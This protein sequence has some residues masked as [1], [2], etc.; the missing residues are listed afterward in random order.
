MMT[1]AEEMKSRIGELI[2]CSMAASATMRY[3][4]TPNNTTMIMLLNPIGIE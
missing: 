2:D 4:T 1:G 3:Q